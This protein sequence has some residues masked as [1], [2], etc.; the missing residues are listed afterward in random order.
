MFA[1]QLK[2]ETSPS[3]A[4]VPHHKCLP[5]P[6]PVCPLCRSGRKCCSV[7]WSPE[8]LACPDLP[9]PS[10]QAKLLSPSVFR[11]E[12]YCMGTKWHNLTSEL[13][14][15]QF[16]CI[17]LI[18]QILSANEKACKLFECTTSEL[19]GKKLPD[20]L[21]KTSQVLEEALEEEF[22]FLDG[23][24]ASVSGKVVWKPKSNDCRS[25]SW[26]SLKFDNIGYSLLQLNLFSF[27]IIIRRCILRS[28]SL[29]SLGGCCHIIWRGASFS[30]FPQTVR[31][32][33]ALPC[34]DG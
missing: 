7:S 14:Q 19:I 6:C 12:R 28:Y 2:Q 25:K 10:T 31:R 18:S 13:H 21:K 20:I 3:L 11:P 29:F 9:L 23:T 17:V 4:Y 8:I 26:I 5:P 1:V 22:L 16:L 15:G 27:A 24:V 32:W 34:H 33:R 30:V